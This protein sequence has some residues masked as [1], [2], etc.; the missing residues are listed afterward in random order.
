MLGLKKTATQDE[1]KKAY[2][3]LAKT[4]YPDLHPDDAGKKAEFQAVAAVHDLL[5]EPNPTNALKI[6][7]FTCSLQ[8][9][10]R[11]CEAWV[12]M[13]PGSNVNAPRKSYLI[14]I[15]A[16]GRNDLFKVLSSSRHFHG[17]GR[18]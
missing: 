7:L 8:N 13:Q 2:R 11:H 6:V 1:I 12:G 14:N 18:D 15:R 4:L 9:M 10:C 16:R 17:S 3:K 5:G